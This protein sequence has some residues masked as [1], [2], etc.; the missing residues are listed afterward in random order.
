MILDQAHQEIKK[1][2]YNK[3]YLLAQTRAKP[4]Y[5]K[6]G[7]NEFGPIIDDEGV[8]HIWMVKTI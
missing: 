5:Q 1:L 4:F 8:D 2:G 7:Y 3:T 6:L